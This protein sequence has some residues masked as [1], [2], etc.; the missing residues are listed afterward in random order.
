MFN[1][2][3]SLPSLDTGVYGKPIIPAE[4]DDGEVRAKMQNLLI[5]GKPSSTAPSPKPIQSP[6]P[7]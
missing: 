5:R 4:K 3:K 6:D 1:D 7:Y 2:L